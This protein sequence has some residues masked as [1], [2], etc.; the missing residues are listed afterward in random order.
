MTIHHIGY[1]VKKMEKAISAF[2]C[3][4]YTLTTDT[5]F[6][7]YR[8]IDI[9]F[10]EKDG[11]CVELISPKSKESAVSDLIKRMGNAP[12]HLCHQSENFDADTA[13]LLEKGFMMMDKPMPA[14][15]LGG[16]RVVFFMHMSMGIIEL[17]DANRG[18]IA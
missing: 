4:G 14:P 1:L 17:L 9:C 5:V 2:L 7:E 11:Y 16:K 13:E 18:E 12:Y 15:A 3:L 8:G 6:D 10:M